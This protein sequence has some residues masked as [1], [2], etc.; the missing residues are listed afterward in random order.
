MC[1]IA[2]TRKSFFDAEAMW[3]SIAKD[4]GLTGQREARA[5]TKGPRGNFL[6]ARPS[7]MIGRSL[8]LVGSVRLRLWLRLFRFVCRGLLRR[9]SLARG[10]CLRLRHQQHARPAVEM[11]VLPRRSD[12]AALR[13]VGGSSVQVQAVEAENALAIRSKLPGRIQAADGSLRRSGN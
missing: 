13:G 8:F 5:K 9:T 4:T 1:A 7:L 11:H 2:S 10:T 3:A 12:H 6:L